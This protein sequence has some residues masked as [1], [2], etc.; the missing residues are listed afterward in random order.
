MTSFHDNANCCDAD[1]GQ[2][3]DRW[4]VEHIIKRKVAWTSWSSS[5]RQLS[6]ATQ[7][8]TSDCWRPGEAF[9]NTRGLARGVCHPKP[10]LP[11]IR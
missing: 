2:H 6:L 5:R 4:L 1:Y 8:P 7:T 11:A 9:W 10:L 3:G